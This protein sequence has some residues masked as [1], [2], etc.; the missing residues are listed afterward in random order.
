[1]ERDAISEIGMD[2]EG[3]LY[4]APETKTFPYIYREAMEVH[5]NE[6]GAISSRRPLHARNLQRLF[7]GSKE[8]FLPRKS[9][10]ANYAFRQIQN[11]TMFR[12]SY[13]VKL[14]LFWRM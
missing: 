10:V 3:R 7:G 5:W 1:M 14:L 6:I 9:K 13:K 12:S 11:G 4:V 2:D 8:Y